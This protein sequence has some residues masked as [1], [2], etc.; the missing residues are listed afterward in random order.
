MVRAENSTSQ[1]L[2]RICGDSLIYC[3][4]PYQNTAGYKNE[5]SYEEFW[6]WVRKTSQNHTVIVSEHQA[7]D[8]FIEIWRKEKAMTLGKGEGLKRIEKLFMHKDLYERL[9]KK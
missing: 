9:N 8:D 6:D 3:D 5:F 1:C 7:P 4:P 2:Q